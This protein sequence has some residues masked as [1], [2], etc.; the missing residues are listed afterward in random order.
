MNITFKTHFPWPGADG[1]PEPTHFA[2]QIINELVLRDGAPRAERSYK[3]HTIRRVKD[4]PRFRE[5][6]RLVLQHGSRFKP[7]PFVE[8]ECTGVQ[9]L[10]MSLL[11]NDPSWLEQKAEAAHYSLQIRIDHPD[12]VCWL[13]EEDV[14]RLARNDGFSSLEQF[15]RW[16][17][18]DVLANGPGTYQLVHWTEVR[19]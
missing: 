11:W 1:Q 2:Q 7:M 9:M 12:D 8:T 3:L 5:G 16:F 19:Y 15:T 4:K 14:E 17:L 6:M 10:H 18:L 13:T